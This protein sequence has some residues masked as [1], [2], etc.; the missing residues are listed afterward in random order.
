VD[1]QERHGGEGH[2]PV[3]RLG[4][5]PAAGRGEHPVGGGQPGADGRGQ[6]DER[7]DSRVEKQKVLDSEGDRVARLCRR[8]SGQCDGKGGRAR[9]EV[10]PV[11]GPV[12]LVTLTAS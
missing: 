3:D 11:T 7:E 10:G 1:R 8:G 9:G 2:G 6:R 5:D 4:G 12:S